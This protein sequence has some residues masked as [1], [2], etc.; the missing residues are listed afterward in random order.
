VSLFDTR[1][2]LYLITQGEA[3][4]TNF[5]QKKK[6][7][8]QIV[9]AAIDVGVSLVQIR[10]KGL[11]GR[12]LF[13]L[14]K[15][16]VEIAEGRETQILVNE[17]FDVAIAAG[18]NGVHLPAKALSAAV[19]RTSVPRLFLIGVSTHNTAEVESAVNGG[20][21]FVTFGPIFESPG[22]GSPVGL[23]ELNIICKQFPDLP[24]I[25]LGGVDESN[26]SDTLDAGAAGIAA[27]R[28]LNG[29]ERLSEIAQR[30]KQHNFR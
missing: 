20:A 29:P 23:E 5:S 13:E 26:L 30:V 10:E 19:V 22:K 17:R 11:E 1:P 3:G 21:D 27:I 12:Q 25:A 15:A 18:A 7:I 14:V 2:L 6:E 16:A 4:P 9:Q 8:L 28:L 24:V